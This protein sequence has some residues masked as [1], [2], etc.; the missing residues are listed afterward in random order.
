MSERKDIPDWVNNERA[1]YGLLVVAKES[2]ERILR[3]GVY[4]EMSDEDT[5]ED[6][7][8]LSRLNEYIADMETRQEPFPD[9][10]DEEAGGDLDS[11]H[12]RDD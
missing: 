7:G 8:I 11:S 10:D 9:D 1:I 6:R 5:E 4:L 2:Y 3:V 12:T